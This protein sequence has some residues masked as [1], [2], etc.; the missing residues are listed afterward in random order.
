[1]IVIAYLAPPVY[2]ADIIA[3]MAGAEEYFLIV[4]DG[5]IVIARED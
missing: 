3:L 5:N 1:M 2:S 4:E